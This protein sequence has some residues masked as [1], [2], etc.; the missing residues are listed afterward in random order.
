[1]NCDITPAQAN[2]WGWHIKW[3]AVAG[4]ETV[5]RKYYYAGSQRVAMRENGNLRWL[6]A[7]HLGGTAITVSGTTETG[8]VRYYPFGAD[9]FTS[10][11][12]PTS[13][14]YTGQR[15]ES[16]IGLYYY[17]ARWYDPALGRFVQPDTIVPDPGDAKSF[18]RYAYVL[19]NP[20]LYADPD[21]HHPCPATAGRCRQPVQLS[22]QAA[23][24]LA[25]HLSD[26]NVDWT[27]IPVNVQR[28]L[29]KEGIHDGIYADLHGNAQV[30]T[31][32]RDPATLAATLYG[33]VR[34]AWRLPA[35]IMGAC[36]DGD[37]TNEVTATQQAV[38]N[39]L[40]AIRN[41]IGRGYNSFNAFKYNEGPAGPGQAWHHIV[42]QSA[43][44]IAN[45]GSQA[46]HNTNNLIRLPHGAGTIHQQVTSYYNSIQ[47]L[48]TGS[49]T[50]RVYEW[51]ATRSFEEQWQF[52]IDIIIRFG[53]QQ[54]IVDQF[55]S[56]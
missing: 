28:A 43:R 12:T 25:N 54:H 1:V 35:L 7:D 6:L 15:Q 13:F 26:L 53:G 16:G 9:R 37:C 39:G 36:G 24:Q 41:G 30:Q 29:Q 50:L 49:P 42:G 21:G 3:L 5:V 31:G 22:N 19:N 46:I 44:N 14:K 38:D 55:G 18:D 45:F 27:D 48:V 10:G 23:D 2:S 17:G 11:S 32:W 51:L 40:H 52:G 56:K 34:L 20:L 8:E 47:P 4:N 33:G